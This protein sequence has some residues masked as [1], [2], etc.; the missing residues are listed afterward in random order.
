[1]IRHSEI[2]DKALRSQIRQKKIL[3][4][5]NIKLKI[6]G[7]LN[8]RTGKRIKKQN[9]IFFSSGQEAIEAGYRPCGHCMKLKYLSWKRSLGGKEIKMI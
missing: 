6:Y 2:S 8:C 4:G 5:G 7:R 3:W 9:R 1:M